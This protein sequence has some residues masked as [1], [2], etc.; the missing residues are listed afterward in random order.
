[1]T[2]ECVHSHEC[3]QEAGRLLESEKTKEGE[4]VCPQ[5]SVLETEDVGGRG[6][7]VREQR[8]I[9]LSPPSPAC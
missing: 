2:Q 9:E 1:M 4:T 8:R 7:R 6:R 3:V 5:I